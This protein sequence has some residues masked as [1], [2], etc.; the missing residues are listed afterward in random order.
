MSFATSR[1]PLSSLQHVASLSSSEI[2]SGSSVSM[3]GPA[4]LFM[5]LQNPCNVL[6]SSLQADKELA[7]STD[8]DPELLELTTP[9]NSRFNTSLNATESAEF[10]FTS[11]FSVVRL[12]CDPD[13][14]MDGYSCAILV[15]MQPRSPATDGSADRYVDNTLLL[16][17]ALQAASSSAMTDCSFSSRW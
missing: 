11:E 10:P 3:H 13:A 12:H 1:Y 7:R 8:P 17:L 16:A 6:L 15:A 5:T 9:A 14:A 2:S 4:W